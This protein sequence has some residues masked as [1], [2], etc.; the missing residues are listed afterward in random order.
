MEP[1]QKDLESPAFNAIWNAIK[2]WDIDRGENGPD[3]RCNYS[4][5]TGTDVM[6][7][8][9]EL[10]KIIVHK[11]PRTLLPAKKLTAEE[12]DNLIQSFYDAPNIIVSSNPTEEQIE[13]M[14]IE[15]TK[16]YLPGCDTKIMAFITHK[17][18]WIKAYKK[19]LNIDTP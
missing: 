9:K 13:E 19:A 8:L 7:I 12:M 15:E 2:N 4:G 14:A 5:A 17:R 1:T 6:A 10:G 11:M 18:F 16:K 3:K